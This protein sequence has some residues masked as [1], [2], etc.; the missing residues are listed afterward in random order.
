LRPPRELEIRPNK[1]RLLSNRVRIPTVREHREN[2]SAHATEA[3]K[4]MR[5]HLT[6]RG[7]EPVLYTLRAG[8]QVVVDGR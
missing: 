5:D 6:K 4:V 1:K 7:R 3:V 8:R 2:V